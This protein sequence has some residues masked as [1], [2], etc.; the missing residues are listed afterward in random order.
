MSGHPSVLPFVHP[1]PP[2]LFTLSL[3][4]YM[5]TFTPHLPKWA[6]SDWSNAK[7]IW[8]KHH[9][10]DD[11]EQMKIQVAMSTSA[12]EPG[13]TVWVYKGSMWAYAW[14]T[15]VRVTLEDP[16]YKDWYVAF[17]PGGS[18]PGG[19]WYSDPC[20][21]INRTLCSD[22]YLCQE[23]SPAYPHGDGDCNAPTCDCGKVPC[24]FYFF[25]HSSTTVVNGQT[26]GQ[27][28]KDTYIFDSNLGTSP[29]VSGFYFGE[30]PSALVPRRPY[31]F[32][33]PLLSPRFPFSHT[34][35]QTTTSQTL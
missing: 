30:C 3:S 34:T 20:D 7:Q 16:A 21:A 15:S 4:S 29:L 25:N 19:G 28:F 24:G 35:I 23:Q 8:T 2:Q 9:P 6:R 11:E 18:K 14:I 17:K 5:G 26:F 13:Q 31:L 27:W 22:R 32:N 10:M 1:A 12:A 33:Q